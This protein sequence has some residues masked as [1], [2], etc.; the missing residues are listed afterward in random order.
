MGKIVGTGIW[1]GFNDGQDE[2]RDK[3]DGWENS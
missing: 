1:R 3:D 2:L